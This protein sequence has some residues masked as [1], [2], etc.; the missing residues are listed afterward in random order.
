MW[1]IGNCA[2]KRVFEKKVRKRNLLQRSK[3]VK[4]TLVNMTTASSQIQT[5]TQSGEKKSI[6]GEK[7]LP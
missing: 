2:E 6:E 7:D 1:T 4:E 3:P 5:R